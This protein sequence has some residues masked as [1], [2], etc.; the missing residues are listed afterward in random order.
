MNIDF[1]EIGRYNISSDG[2]LSKIIKFNPPLEDPYILPNSTVSMKIITPYGYDCTEF[3]SD[4]I[5]IRET[6]PNN[7]DV[8]ILTNVNI[9]A[10][11]GVIKFPYNNFESGRHYEIM[12]PSTAKIDNYYS[13]AKEGGLI[14]KIRVAG[15]EI[16][17]IRTSIE[18][19]TKTSESY[20]DITIT[21]NYFSNYEP[22][23]IVDGRILSYL[24]TS[25]KPRLFL[26]NGTE[27]LPNSE[28]G[29]FDVGY[30]NAKMTIRNINFNN[31]A[32]NI[33]MTLEIKRDCYADTYI[34]CTNALKSVNAISN[35]EFF[36]SGG[37]IESQLIG[38]IDCVS[39]ATIL[40]GLE[41]ESTVYISSNY[42][43]RIINGNKCA[44][45]C[46]KKIKN[47]TIGNFFV[48]KCNDN[49]KS[50]YYLSD[51]DT[52]VLCE[53]NCKE[54][55]GPNPDDCIECNSR[56]SEYF[57][58]CI[59]ENYCNSLESE[60][61]Y[62]GFC[63]SGYIS[64]PYCMKTLM[65][66]SLG[67][68]FEY[69]EGRD[70]VS[71]MALHFD[72]SGKEKM[73]N[74]SWK[75]IVP[76]KQPITPFR[77]GTDLTTM[78]NITQE[79]ITAMDKD[80]IVLFNFTCDFCPENKSEGSCC[81]SYN[82]FPV[83]HLM[84][85]KTGV[86]SINPRQG[87]A[88]ST[89]F[90]VSIFNMSISKG[91]TLRVD[92]I[93]INKESHE[94]I[95]LNT[96]REIYYNKESISFGKLPTWTSIRLDEQKEFEVYLTMMKNN[97]EMYQFKSTVR[98]TNN[99]SAKESVKLEE[100]MTID[101]VNRMNNTI[102][103]GGNCSKDC[104][105]ES[106]DI[107][108]AGDL[109]MNYNTY[110]NNTK[111]CYTNDDCNNGY[112][113]YDGTCN[114][115]EG[116][117]G[118][119]CRYTITHIKNINAIKAL[120][121]TNFSNIIENMGTEDLISISKNIEIYKNITDVDIEKKIEVFLNE[122]KKNFINE[123][124]II[125]TSDVPN[126]EDIIDLS[127]NMLDYKLKEN[128][129]EGTNNMVEI[130]DSAL[131]KIGTVLLPGEE[132]RIIK[133]TF[134]ATLV[135]TIVPTSDNDTFEVGGDEFKITV[136]KNVLSD[137]NHKTSLKMRITNWKTNPYEN[138]ANNSKSLLSDLIGITIIGDSA[139][140]EF[141][142]AKT[143]IVSFDIKSKKDLG[144]GMKYQCVYYE[145]CKI[146]YKFRCRTK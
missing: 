88:S 8:A 110:D 58:S 106:N 14:Q 10:E 32:G 118:N 92:F 2:S 136:N 122:S 72:F 124:S 70:P 103:P 89:E 21:G 5:T 55:V 85:L 97:S 121:E 4:N 74:P 15:L 43:Y 50:G 56:Y 26:E 111:R 94:L 65:L 146:N 73:E 66:T 3:Y 126:I 62:R 105:I 117:S 115:N 28:Y 91:T 34:S 81:T 82:L 44:S 9:T 38:R 130:I 45:Y 142:D 141:N 90:E 48:E 137:L 100:Q 131:D 16:T 36:Y 77:K 12:I 29:S 18:Y 52:C 23:I 22:N 107:I 71:L 125:T 144:K 79:Y 104:N 138:F 93:D 113:I 63:L 33:Y 99:I 116:Y 17:S 139:A 95:S 57:L 102:Y 31:S 132:K 86:I 64:N 114:C 75:Q 61:N 1:I 134:E 49:C 54:C 46:N 112:C 37:K 13:I 101:I 67:L 6:F 98:V 129:S 78:A 30:S 135:D 84:N 83:N 96:E 128:N 123:S 133:P 68:Q 53:N 140:K 145:K 69:K 143:P 59:N 47:V 108:I 109:L 27:L 76:I 60:R 7:R 39:T 40:E 35:P 51:D 87:I 20:G 120:I 127:S 42:P 19:N 11:N 25:I 119:S 24:T 41:V 80:Q